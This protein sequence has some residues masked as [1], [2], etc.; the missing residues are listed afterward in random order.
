M[1]MTCERAATKL[2]LLLRQWS[3]YPPSPARGKLRRG[4]LRSPSEVEWRWGE[5]NSRPQCK[6]NRYLHV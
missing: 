5:S 6:A 1:C 4:R 2:G 3:E